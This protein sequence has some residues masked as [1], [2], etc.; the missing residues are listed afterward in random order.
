MELLGELKIYVAIMTAANDPTSMAKESAHLKSIPLFFW[1]IG[2][3]SILNPII[4]ATLV[5]CHLHPMLAY[6]YSLG[7]M[8][9]TY[10]NQ[11]AVTS[12]FIKAVEAACRHVVEAACRHVVEAAC[13][14]AAEA[15]SDSM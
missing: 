6:A 14:H 12:H 13:R 5:E 3:V 11:E 4:G 7:H 15:V 1:Y 9:A 8:I 2:L 10:C